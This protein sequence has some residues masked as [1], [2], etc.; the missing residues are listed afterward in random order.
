MEKAKIKLFLQENCKLS[1]RRRIRPQLPEI[2]PSCRFLDTHLEDTLMQNIVGFCI[3][4]R[5]KI[6][7]QLNRAEEYKDSS[8]YKSLRNTELEQS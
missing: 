7:I 5:K 2:V 6:G 1:K 4:Q 3:S 8:V